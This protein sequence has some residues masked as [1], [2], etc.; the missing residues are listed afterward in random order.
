MRNR[1]PT[2][3][4]GRST[5]TS[6]FGGPKSCHLFLP[7]IPY[8]IYSMY[9]IFACICY[10]FWPTVGKY[11][12]HGAFGYESIFVN[13][14]HW[15]CYF[16]AS[17][18]SQIDMNHFIDILLPPQSPDMRDTKRA[19]ERRDALKSYRP[20]REFLPGVSAIW[21]SSIQPMSPIKSNQTS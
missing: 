1:K 16:S 10:R 18:W 2:A 19:N 17:K 4:R 9:G 7:Y 5:I 15:F 8:P 21:F 13:S 14:C 20:S 11:S 12:I 3:F 6:L